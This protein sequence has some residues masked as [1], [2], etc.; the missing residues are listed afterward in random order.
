MDCW[1]ERTRKVIE[2]T[3]NG[4]S[5]E[6]LAFRPDSNW[7]AAQILEH[8]SLAFAGTAKG[9][10]RVLA[11]GAVPQS[12]RR[13]KDRISTLVVVGLGYMPGGRKAPKGTVPGDGDPSNILAAI[14]NN[15]AL[16]DE[17]LTAVEKAK[18]SR[19]VLPH[20]ILGPLALA[21]WRKFHYVHTA[22]HMKQ[23]ERLKELQK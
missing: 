13:M 22:H 21:Q 1:L 16:M 10:E 23:I 17:R 11:G 9:M 20:P 2:K 7:S 12:P 3:A 15:L 14:L 8:L 5:P 4:M 6:Q 19:I 18:G